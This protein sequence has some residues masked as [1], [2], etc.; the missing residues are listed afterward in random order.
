M[1]H[2]HLLKGLD[3]QF[4]SLVDRAAVRSP[5]APTEPQRYLLWKSERSTQNEGGEM[6]PTSEELTAALEKAEQDRDAAAT[7]AE[8][9]EEQVA[10]LTKQ[11]EDLTVK[12]N[13][14]TND[15]DQQD[16]D[17]IDLEKAD[18]P[19]AVKTAL[20]K[21]QE[22]EAADAERIAKA[23]SEAAEASQIAKAERDARVTREFVTKAEQYGALPGVNAETFGPVLKSASEKLTKDESD[24]LE[25][26]LKAA[27]EAI[28]KSELMK[29]QG[30]GGRTEAAADSARAE[31]SKR[32][33]DLKKSD[34]SLS[35]YAAEQAVLKADPE[36]AQRQVAE[37]RGA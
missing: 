3:V 28:S 1:P 7:R 32:A 35:D 17:E 20:R 30:R 15:D 19:A 26:V 34:S 37:A 9:S 33:A 22:R 24:A 8:K 4:V 14:A 2:H 6:P 16:D 18:L 13:K 31:V 10:T 11:V 23:E 25:T 12:V 27:N 29:E 36:L 5:D 21:A